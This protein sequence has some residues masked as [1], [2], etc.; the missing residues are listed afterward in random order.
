MKIFCREENSPPDSK[1]KKFHFK[2]FSICQDNT[3]WK[4][5]TDGVVLGA[6]AKIAGAENIL[7]IGTGT[8]IIALM[9]AQRNTTAEIDA[10]EIDENTADEARMNVNSS[11]WSERIRIINSSIETFKPGKTYDHIVSNPPYF[12]ESASTPSPDKKRRKARHCPAALFEIIIGFSVRHTEREGKLSVVLP[13]AE[14]KIFL[15]TA[16]TYG[17]YPSRITYLIPNPGKP[18]KRF[19]IELEKKE[20]TETIID[21]IIIEN[22]RNDYHPSYRNLTS[23]FHPHL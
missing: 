3:V 1:M 12:I 11:P 7:D 6:W 19:L 23:E 5:G 18:A 21:R 4:V 8:G 10:L 22:S 13:V 9:C 2:Q 20:K 16:N 14:A 17:L 15:T